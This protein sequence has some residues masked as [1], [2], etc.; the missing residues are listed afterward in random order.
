MQSM[1]KE[2]NDPIQKVVQIKGIIILVEWPKGST[3]T[4]KGSDYKR[5]MRCD[6]GYIRGTEGADGEELDVYVGDDLESDV[7]F[8]IEQLKRNGSYDEDKYMVGFSTEEEAREMFALHM[9]EDQMGDVGEMSLEEFR[10]LC[11]REARVAFKKESAMFKIG[12][13]V[14]VVAQRQYRGV[15]KMAYADQM[16]QVAIPRVGS[17]LLAKQHLRPVKIKFA[18]ELQEADYIESQIEMLKSDK[19]DSDEEAKG[20]IDIRIEELENELRKVQEKTAMKDP[21][22]FE[23]RVGSRRIAK[24]NDIEKGNEDTLRSPSSKEVSEEIPEHEKK[25]GFPGNGPEREMKLAGAENDDAM[26][27]WMFQTYCQDVL[28][29]DENAATCQGH[30]RSCQCDDHIA[31]REDVRNGWTPSKKQADMGMETSVGA[32]PVGSEDMLATAD[33]CTADECTAEEDPEHLKSER[34]YYAR[35]Q[36]EMKDE[37]NEEELAALYKQGVAPEGW[38][39]SINRM[40]K[41]HPNIDN[42]WALSWWMK[43]KGYKPHPQKK[44]SRLAQVSVKETWGGDGTVTRDIK[45]DLVDATEVE[46]LMKLLQ[47]SPAQEDEIEKEEM[48]SPADQSAETGT[49]NQSPSGDGSQENPPFISPSNPGQ[50]VAMKKKAGAESMWDARPYAFR[51]SVLREE[52][53]EEFEQDEYARMS[54]NELKSADPSLWKSISKNERIASVKKVAMNDSY[55]EVV[56]IG[57]EV[58]FQDEYGNEPG[59]EGVISDIGTPDGS[60]QQMAWVRDHNGKCRWCDSSSIKK[61]ASKKVAAT[62]ERDESAT[63]EVGDMVETEKGNGRIIDMEG[64]RYRGYANPPEAGDVRVQ[65]EN[66]QTITV[67]EEDVIVLRPSGQYNPLASKKTAGEGTE[68]FDLPKG[69]FDEDET[70]D[71]IPKQKSKDELV[72]TSEPMPTM[73]KP[74]MGMHFRDGS[75]DHYTVTNILGDGRIELTRM[76]DSFKCYVDENKLATSFQK[77]SEMEDEAGGPGSGRRPGMGEPSGKGGD[78]AFHPDM[79]DN[80]HELTDE[81]LGQ[82]DEHYNNVRDIPA[83]EKVDKEI[84]RRFGSESQETS[85]GQEQGIEDVYA[86]CGIAENVSK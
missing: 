43:D 86:K 83:R 66:G 50:N 5:K 59:G 48:Q 74:E 14:T 1:Y 85:D 30:P 39:N 71:I 12:D 42:P 55:G 27:Q 79:Q 9:P 46:A 17:V 76:T 36:A 49:T 57:D 20:A 68:E 53:V 75:G 21:D 41:H 11:P 44:S 38:G 80:F 26:L 70:H 63:P 31:F 54:S 65:L 13:A 16:F 24:E 78:K 6:Y 82:A 2:A 73:V 29:E 81:G 40:K 34:E 19:K 37:Y 23:T 35:C 60:S 56:N 58:K 67:N 61:I 4:W 51:R 72:K 15:I 25:V 47:H 52:G 77:T 32:P 8:K 64:V 10:E 62:W 84:K 22:F 7:V 33:E 69:F 45:F 18:T 3:R 28:G